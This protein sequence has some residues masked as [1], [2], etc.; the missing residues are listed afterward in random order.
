MANVCPILL[1]DDE[2]IDVSDLEDVINKAG[3]VAGFQ[4][5]I[6]VL[7][8]SCE[9]A[10]EYMEQQKEQGHGISA[11]ISDNHIGTSDIDGDDFLR[12]LRGRLPYC[13]SRFEEDAYLQAR[14]FR[15][16]NQIEQRVRRKNENISSFILNS[17]QDYKDYLN[18]SDY[19]FG[20]PRGETPTLMLCGH[21]QEANLTGLETT[22]LVGKDNRQA[23]DRF[24]EI[25]VM[26]FLTNLGIFY[27]ETIR[28]AITYNPRLSNPNLKKQRYNP[29]SAH[30]KKMF[31]D[32]YNL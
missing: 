3:F 9:D 22:H 19:Y 32:H 20:N 27:K 8:E 21:P 30:T 23:K 18:F 24:C 6:A 5:N 26:D 1:V 28:E 4:E 2:Y 10:I 14:H 25:E 17:F 12:I 15:S 16:L 7:C 13:F 11:L 29:C 31:R